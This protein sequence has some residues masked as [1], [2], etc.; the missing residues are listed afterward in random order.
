MEL[1]LSGSSIVRASCFNLNMFERLFINPASDRLLYSDGL[2]ET[3]VNRAEKRIVTY[4]EGT[5]IT[6]QS[7]D[8]EAFEQE[9]IRERDFAEEE[10]IKCLPIQ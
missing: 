9:L 3:R 1:T 5:V 8:D 6:I 4:C 10:G 2:I 7:P